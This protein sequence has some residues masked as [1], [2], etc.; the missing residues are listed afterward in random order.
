MLTWS[1]A[2]VSSFSSAAIFSAVACGRY[3]LDLKGWKSAGAVFAPWGIYRRFPRRV[4]GPILRRIAPKCRAPGSSAGLPAPDDVIRPGKHTRCQ[5]V[6]D[7]LDQPSGGIQSS[8][9]PVGGM[10]AM[11]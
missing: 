11:P 9:R 2:S 10:D 7:L 5:Q 3:Q 1:P 8:G 4:R 6:D